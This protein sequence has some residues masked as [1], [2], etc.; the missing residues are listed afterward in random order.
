VST[1]AEGVVLE[2]RLVNREEFAVDVS[3]RFIDDIDAQLP[4][5][6]VVPAGGSVL[7][8]FDRAPVVPGGPLEVVVD[9]DRAG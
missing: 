6:V 9:V 5:G 2:A 8:R 3:N 7:L 1:D 4:A